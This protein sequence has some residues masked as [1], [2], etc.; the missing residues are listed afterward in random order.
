MGDFNGDGKPDVAVTTAAGNG[1]LLD[2]LTGNGAGGFSSFVAYPVGA[3]PEAMTTGD[4]NGDGKLDL[5]YADSATGVFTMLGNGDGAFQAP[6][7]VI[8]DSNA[9]SVATADF[10]GDGIPDLAERSGLNYEV[11][12]GRG[13]GSFFPSST[14][15]FFPGT[16]FGAVGD[17]NGDGAPDIVGTTT[18]NAFTGSVAVVLNAHDDLSNLAGAV[19]FRVT[20]AGTAVAGTPFSVT[21][22][23][24]DASGNPVPG[25]RG[26][27]YLGSTDPKATTTA[28]SYTFTAAD[29]GAHTFTNAVTARTAGTESITASAPLMATGSA[30]LAVVPGAAARFATSSAGGVAG[31]PITVTVAAFDAF[32]NP[33]TNTTDTVNIKSSDGQSFPNAF[34]F[35]TADA[36]VHQFRE[37]ITIASTTT[38][39]VTDAKN[40][41]ATTSST[42]FQIDPATVRRLVVKTVGFVDIIAGLSSEFEVMGFDAFNNFVLNDSSSAV[43][44]SATNIPAPFV[45]TLVDGQLSFFAAWLKAGPQ[46]ITAALVSDPTVTG[47]LSG[48]IVNPAGAASLN[49][50]GGA[51]TTAGAPYAVTVTVFDAFGNLATNFTGA[52]QLSSTDPRASVPVYFFTPADAGAH[53]FFIAMGT[54]GPQFIAVRFSP[55]PTLVTAG[56]TVVVAPTT[57]AGFAVSGFPATTVGVAQGFTVTALDAFG[58]PTTNYTGTVTFSS[59]DAQAGLPASYTFTAA[60]AGSHTFSAT[61]KTAGSQSI[62]VADAASPAE[63]GAEA[64]IPVTA[65]AATHFLITPPATATAGK[66][67]TVTVTALDAFG[68]VATGYRG[69]VQFKDSA[70]NSGLPSA[71]TFGATDLGVHVFTLTLATT[72]PQLLTLADLVSPTITGGLSLDLGTH[73]QGGRQDGLTRGRVVR[74]GAGTFSRGPRG[75][76]PTTPVQASFLQREGADARHAVGLAGPRFPPNLNG[77]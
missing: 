19:A 29:A 61:L 60:D 63:S 74:D 51:T 28:P 8:P 1:S 46:S 76:P 10:N 68:N 14:Y 45:G 54:A 32:G 13:D 44:L 26:T 4:F 15:A 6:A 25:F 52:V 42:P 67:F 73:P 43:S 35:T 75:G 48:L 17:F 3:N 5:A 58:N 37:V 2:V 77:L 56:L 30:P 40:P 41:A 34:T 16:R 70:G 59:S 21:V 18:N 11:E 49:I 27:V 57:T 47:T 64:A 53:T 71:Y 23:A 39:T 31:Q 50:S 66:A 7:L 22:T 38:V 24:V 62:G 72:G 12:L 69:K 65:G 9:Q 33:A 36:G 55:S 20:D